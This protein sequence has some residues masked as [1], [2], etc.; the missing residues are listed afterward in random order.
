MGTFTAKSLRS[1]DVWPGNKI[2]QTFFLTE[3]SVFIDGKSFREE[4]LS[5]GYQ[6]RSLL[7]EENYWGW[8]W[9]SSGRCDVSV[10]PVASAVLR[11][12]VSCFLLTL[13][14]ILI[15]AKFLR[16]PFWWP[17]E[18]NDTGYSLY[19]KAG[20]HANDSP[21]IRENLPW[22]CWN[23]KRFF[24]CKKLRNTSHLQYRINCRISRTLWL[25]SISVLSYWNRQW[26]LLGRFTAG[27][28]VV[29]GEM[30]GWT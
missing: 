25:S 24:L 1:G 22:H 8:R 20:I 11:P 19:I 6:K 5:T 23:Q 28:C 30:P 18:G 9:F 27:P 15:S 26:K 10:P 4:N 14:R 2:V 21:T 7:E 13:L 12:Y 17:T 16:R 3:R 29:G